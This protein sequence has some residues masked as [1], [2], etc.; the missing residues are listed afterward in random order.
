[1]N[2]K[3]YLRFKSENISDFD[4]STTTDGNIIV[5]DRF[6]GQILLII[7]GNSP[8]KDLIADSY[9]HGYNAGIQNM[10]L[11]VEFLETLTS[12]MVP[13]SDSKAKIN[14][15]ARPSPTFKSFSGDNNSTNSDHYVYQLFLPNQLSNHIKQIISSC[16]VKHPETYYAS[17]ANS[18]IEDAKLKTN[19]R[20]YSSPNFGSICNVITNKKDHET[21]LW[22]S[23]LS[24]YSV[25]SLIYTAICE[26]TAR[27]LVFLDL[28]QPLARIDNVPIHHNRREN[29]SVYENDIPAILHMTPMR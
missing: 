8:Q 17:A 5:R 2:H 23:T 19:I 3:D 28:D 10:K 7:D 12:P 24:G 11:Y 20:P 13:K 6:D 1:M 16:E 4:W 27:M 25:T 15:A 22:L 29:K 21:Y 9:H 26:T 18:W 14:N